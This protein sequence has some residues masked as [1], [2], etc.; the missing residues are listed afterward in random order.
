[1]DVTVHYEWDPPMGSGPEAIIDYYNIMI[2]PEPVLNYTSNVI[3]STSSNVTLDYNVQY[4]ISVTS[5]NCAGKS[6][7]TVHVLK[8]GMHGHIFY[9][10]T[11]KGQCRN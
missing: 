4:T 3:D 1:M 11:I 9:N 10:L 8:F 6:L 7:S 5:V 2:T